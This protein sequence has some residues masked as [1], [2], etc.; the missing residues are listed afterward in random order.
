MSDSYERLRDDLTRLSG[1]LQ[2]YGHDGQARVVDEIV[3]SFSSPDPDLKRLSGIDMWGGSGAVWEVNLAPSKTTP[4]AR[5]DKNSFCR[6]I[7]RVAEDLDRLGI[8]TERS[9]FVARVFEEW[10]NK[11]IV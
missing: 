2:K 6:S 11:G 8:G 3:A 5:M 1:M 9:R 7:I 10:I 4:E